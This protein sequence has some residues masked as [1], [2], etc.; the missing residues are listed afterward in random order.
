VVELAFDPFVQLGTLTLRWQTIGVTVAL[1]LGLTLAARNAARPPLRISDLLLILVGIVP[2]AI[3]VGRLV[4][5]ITYQE[6]YL[7]QPQAA[8]DPGTGSLSLL[9]AVVGG[10]LS[11]SFVARS[12]GNDVVRWADVAA[13]PML[14][15]IGIGKLAMLLGGSGQGVPFDGPWAVAF[16]GNGPWVSADPEMPSHPSQIYEGLWLLA[17]LPILGLIGRRRPLGRGWMFVFALCWFLVGRLLVGFT[18]R[19]T[20][21]IGPF[22]VEQAICGALLL[23]V[24]VAAL[25]GG[26]SS[27]RPI[28][29]ESPPAPRR[30]AYRPAGDEGVS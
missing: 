29:A 7:T 24:A 10:C 5:V 16:G 8:F 11:A 19:D 6:F 20:A 15:A 22:N 17:G 27:D 23:G 26:G 18:W 3:V 13:A 25:R 4:H 14:V 1:L 30:H 21:A 12:V 9:G 28:A 2:G